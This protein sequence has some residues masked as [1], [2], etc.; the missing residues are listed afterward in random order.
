MEVRPPPTSKEKSAAHKGGSV[1]GA[2]LD[3]S[4]GRFDHGSASTMAADPQNLADRHLG[5]RPEGST[6]G[7]S[8]DLAD[9]CASGADLCRP[10][11][12]AIG[13]AEAYSTRTPHV[14]ADLI[15]GRLAAGFQA[16]TSTD[17]PA[18]ARSEV[19]RPS[20]MKSGSETAMIKE[21]FTSGTPKISTK[22]GAC[23]SAAV[24]GTQA[25]VFGSDVA[26][27]PPLPARKTVHDSTT[28]HVNPDGATCTLQA[29]ATSQ[30]DHSSTTPEQ[31]AT[32]AAA[33][34]GPESTTHA[35]NRSMVPNGTPSMDESEGL[36]IALVTTQPTYATITKPRDV[37]PLPNFE[38]SGSVIKDTIEGMP[39]LH[40][41][42][43]DFDKAK[44]NF[45]FSLIMRFTRV[46]PKLE[47]IRG[48]INGTWG[49]S[50]AAVGVLDS[51]RVLIRLLN[52]KDMLFALSKNHSSIDKVRY[53]LFKW[54][55]NLGKKAESPVVYKWL[56]LPGLQP[57]LCVNSILALI[58]NSFARFIEAD[59]E[60]ANTMKP[61]HPR[62]CV[63]IDL[64]KPIPTKVF[65]QIGEAEGYWQPIA[66]EGNPV[67][68]SFCKMHGHATLFCRRRIFVE[69]K[70]NTE[71]SVRKAT[72]KEVWQPKQVAPK[73]LKVIEVAVDVPAHSVNSEPVMPPSLD[74]VQ[75]K[76]AV[77][78]SSD[79][80]AFDEVWQPVPKA[81]SRPIQTAPSSLVVATTPTSN[82]FSLLG[83]TDTPN[84]TS[85]TPAIQTVPEGPFEAQSGT[86]QGTA[87]NI[88]PKPSQ[89]AHD[90]E[91]MP[92]PKSGTRIATTSSQLLPFKEAADQFYAE[93]A[94]T[95]LSGEAPLQS[96]EEMTAS[97]VAY[98]AKQGK[99]YY[100]TPDDAR[101]AGIDVDSYSQVTKRKNRKHKP[102]ADAPQVTART[103]NK[104]SK[105][106][107]A[108]ALDKPEGLFKH[109]SSKS[110]QRKASKDQ[111]DTSSQAPTT[112]ADDDQHKHTSRSRKRHTSKHR[113]DTSIPSIPSSDAAAEDEDPLDRSL[114]EWEP[115]GPC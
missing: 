89:S 25:V 27:F 72:T 4:L 103:R 38:I 43:V 28:Q 23:K 47:T 96:I 78:V 75:P 21:S 18:Q 108:A 17:L 36:E 12:S 85:V 74:I 115:N 57:E 15:H 51:R 10:G 97:Y 68:C 82:R 87:S 44:A 105:E 41:S 66:F 34:S 61:A 33:T 52:E 62:I 86:V 92:P 14:Q 77:E 13:S 46:R 40:I 29:A 8:S 79:W 70:K 104:A 39:A 65:I 94:N 64:T 100:P 90:S 88:T 109:T 83:E 7:A 67:Y 111:S 84:G 26:A 113:A 91:L 35:V 48:I 32:Q 5:R 55:S 16:R 95:D 19:D 2:S 76:H 6:A 1:Q 56:R 80:L 73:P 114:S 37:P 49:I 3:S 112:D 54:Q 58:G 71:P 99:G 45:A 11:R 50:T 93:D 53:S 63:E 20:S 102:A 81:S 101:R 98:L 24:Q 60:T 59:P 22:D 110:R 107:L 30:I 106:D 42:Q 69:E 9:S 31:P